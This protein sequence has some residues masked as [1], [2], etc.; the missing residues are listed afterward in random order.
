M[1]LTQLQ[2]RAAL[3]PTWRPFFA[4]ASYA[5]PTL[6]W[7]KNTFYPKFW[8]HRIQLGLKPYSRRNDCDNFA[9]SAAQYAQDCHALTPAALQGTKA[10]GLAFGE[11]WYTK[12][13][14]T[15]LHAICALYSGGL[16]F[17]EPQNG[18]ILTL[19]QAEILSVNYARF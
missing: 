8:E 19:T 10:E 3:P 16:H 18:A 9:R 1:I 12:S 5:E 13:D 14:G 2:L 17:I 15:G 11:I 7:V 6:A 4:D